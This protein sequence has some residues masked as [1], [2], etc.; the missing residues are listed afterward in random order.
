MTNTDIINIKPSHIKV[1]AVFI[2]IDII[3]W[4]LW[5]HFQSQDCNFSHTHRNA[6]RLKQKQKDENV[7]VF[8]NCMFYQ[9]SVHLF[10]FMSQGRPGPPGIQGPVGP[11][12]PR[13]LE[14]KRSCYS[15]NLFSSKLHKQHQIEGQLFLGLFFRVVQVLLVHPG[16]R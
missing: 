10:P 1:S 12:G 6:H 13:G 3:C 4:C 5:K 2:I 16:L 8:L 7:Q 11:P 14:V 15:V 9:L